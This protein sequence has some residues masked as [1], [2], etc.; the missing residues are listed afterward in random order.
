[1]NARTATDGRPGDDGSEGRRG[2][3]QGRLLVSDYA[4]RSAADA[5]Q[6]IRR[7]GLRPGLERSLGYEPELVGQVVAQE[8]ASGSELV[9]NGMVTLYVAAP[10]PAPADEGAAGSPAG[11]S[12]SEVPSAAPDDALALESGEHRT[13]VRPRRRRKR[14][15]A[16]LSPRVFDT[17][18]APVRPEVNLAPVA[19]GMLTEEQPTDEWA[20][21]EALRIDDP[22]GSNTPDGVRD[23]DGDVELPH[24]ELVVQAIEVFAGR[25]GVPWPRVYPTRRRLTKP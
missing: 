8:P 2:K 23:H 6:A 9:R 19:S 7:A 12:E 13:E 10:G 14:R 11:S 22:C 20:S 18:P 5:A 16:D 25:A 1:M 21:D 17:P 15:P 4:G 24:H 3:P